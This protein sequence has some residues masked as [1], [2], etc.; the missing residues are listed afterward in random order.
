[1]VQRDH[2]FQPA[3]TQQPNHLT[4]FGQRPGIKLA[5][6]GLDAAPL[7]RDAQAV[8]PKPGRAVEIVRS[9]FQIP[10]VGGRAAHLAAGDAARLLLPQGPIVSVVAAFVLV[11]SGGG[12]PAEAIGKMQDVVHSSIAN[13]QA[14]CPSHRSR[15]VQQPSA[16]TS[17]RPQSGMQPHS[18]RDNGR[19]RRR[20]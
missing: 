18:R 20:A 19:R 7:D 6:V 9:H 15:P 1:M 4:V 10:P 11:R 2:R 3:L 13:W 12:A 8:E 5:R 16:R 14:R 17:H